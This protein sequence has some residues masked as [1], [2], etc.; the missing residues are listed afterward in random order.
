MFFATMSLIGRMWRLLL[1]LQI[2]TI[3]V[4]ESQLE[5]HSSRLEKLKKLILSGDGRKK[6]TQQRS[7][8]DRMREFAITAGVSPNAI[9]TEDTRITPSKMPKCALV[10]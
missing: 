5:Y 7:E 6:D 4:T 3:C 9:I 2:L 10:Y 8:A 1:A